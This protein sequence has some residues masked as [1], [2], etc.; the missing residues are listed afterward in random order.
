MT[1][2]NPDAVE[3]DTSKPH[4]AR[5]YDWFLGGKDNYPVDEL[6]AEEL[7]ALDT[8]GRDMARVNRAFMHRAT[9]WLVGN[10]VRQFL[11]IGTGIPTEPNLHQIAQQAAPDARVV[12]CDNDPIVL[13]HAAALLRSTPEGA[14][15]YIQADARD[16]ESILD[17]A[18]EILDF[19]RPVALSL[20]ALL[21]FVDDEDGAAELVDRLLG[22]LCSGSYLVL[23]HTT[24]DFDPEGAAQ[25]RALYRARG[26][27]LRPRTRVEFTRFFH[28]LELV[29]PGVALSAEWHPE[30]GEV[31]DVPGHDPIPGYAGVARKR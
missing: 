27:T 17:A 1:G 14:T 8:R 10:G 20:L 12:Y 19:G 21:H 3:I 5:M 9:R 25:A 28:G 16:S 23:S 26:M 22:R 2:Q 31:I 7:L 24:G 29:E 4:P 11:D 6:M 18:G 13:A 15:E 30:L